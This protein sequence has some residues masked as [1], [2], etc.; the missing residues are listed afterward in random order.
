MHGLI[1]LQWWGYIAITL[2]LTHMTIASVTIYLHRCQ[3]HRAL[4]LHPIASHLFR[5]WLWF[6]T[7][8][9]TKQWAAIHRKHHA[10]CETEDD[11]HSPQI[12]G[13]KKVLF[14]GYELYKKE[15]YCKETLE[16]YGK[17]TPDDWVER[18]VYSRRTYLG[19]SLMFL[20]DVVLFG[21]IGITMW[22]VQMAWIPVTAA[23]VINGIGHYW[24]YRNFEANDSSTNII[25]WGI[26]I[27]GEELHNNHHAYAS[28]ARLSNKWYELDIGWLYIRLLAS[29]KLAKIKKVAP[30][31]KFD[32]AKKQCDLDTLQAVIT[33]RF[34]VMKT[35]GHVLRKA[36]RNEIGKIH[37]AIYQHGV[38]NFS[39]KSLKEWLHIDA[40]E[41]KEKELLLVNKVL[42]NAHQL[43]TVYHFKQELNQIWMRS[44]ISQDQLLKNLEDWCHRAE[45][46]GIEAL[47]EFSRRLRCYKMA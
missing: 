15:S 45:R 3:A 7:G 26:L 35:Y 21:P 29:L 38:S 30:K 34:E 12:L 23:G 22:A 4:D 18:N 43:K 27:G 42:E 41:L 40:N 8:T 37:N 17:G 31:I 47:E 46:S 25:P 28:S 24:G 6:S 10:H 5:F 39:I 19:I 36:Y 44:S 2:L 11:P 14:T 32:W 9:V 20:I 1:S 13:I 33:H 16:K